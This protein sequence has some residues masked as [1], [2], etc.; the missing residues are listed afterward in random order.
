M[1]FREFKHPLIEADEITVPQMKKEIVSQVE[2][3]TDFNLLD[4][5]YQV[6]SHSTNQEKIE[7]AFGKSVNTGNL[8]PTKV[9]IDDMMQQISS[10]AGTTMQ[11]SDFVESLE[12][13][14]AVNTDALL[15]KTSSFAKI[16]SSKFAEDFFMSIANYGRGSKMKGPGEFALAIM[17]PD[18]ALAEKGD[19]IINGRHVEVKSALNKSGGRLGEVGANKETILPVLSA[20]AMQYAKTPAQQVAMK[21]FLA[22]HSV[23]IVPAVKRLHD[24]FDGDKTAIKAIIS[25]AIELTLGKKFADKIGTAATKDPSGLMAEQ[26]Y[27]RSN[28]EW[29]K[30]R[31]G[32]DE[33]LA[34][35]FGGRKTFSFESGDELLQLRASGSFGSAGVSFIPTKPNEVFAQINFTVGG[36]ASAAVTGGPVAAAPTGG[37]AKAPP[38]KISAASGG[39]KKDAGVDMGR[40][41]R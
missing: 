27:M 28:F 20:T 35:W 17:S 36:A 4:R 10:L 32:F 34:I 38:E 1:R 21:G 22:L 3:T 23:G 8:G 30:E 18:I 5:V 41:K 31:D 37:T 11:K 29:Y 19:L 39:V 14:T 7:L 25:S 33:I 24:I 26:E 9:I 6:L 13:G 12:N 15:S 16:F 2:D 40:A